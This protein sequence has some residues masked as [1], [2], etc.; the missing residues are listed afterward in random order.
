MRTLLNPEL[1]FLLE[2]ERKRHTNLKLGA[3]ISTPGAE[4]R[5]EDGVK[6]DQTNQTI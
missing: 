2:Q 6:L 1:G 4:K 5:W 3:C